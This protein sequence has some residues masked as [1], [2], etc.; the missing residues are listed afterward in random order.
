MDGCGVQAPAFTAEPDA[1][2]AMWQDQAATAIR[3]RLTLY[4]RLVR[5]L[6]LGERPEWEQLGIVVRGCLVQA[7][8]LASAHYGLRVE[9]DLSADDVLPSLSGQLYTHQ[10]LAR[11]TAGSCMLVAPTGSGKTE[12]ALLWAARQV[13]TGALRGYSIHC[14]IRRA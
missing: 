4:R 7:D 1:V 2:L 9:L 10:V 13:E 8:H 5:Q 3:R 11:Q 14:L 12:A 6:A